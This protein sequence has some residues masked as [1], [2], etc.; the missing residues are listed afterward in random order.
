MSETTIALLG[1][2]LMGSG[3]AGRL[4]DAGYPL[5]VYNRNATK[6][7]PLVA[8]GATLTRSPREAAAGASVVISMLSDVPVARDLWL[9]RGEALVDIA[10]GTILVESSTVTVDW[11]LELNRAATEHGCVLVDAPVTGSRAQ[12]AAGQLLF[13]AGGPTDTLGK[14]DPVLRAMGRDVVHVGPVG[15]GAR[16]KLINNFLSGVQTAALAEALSMIERS[17]LDTQ[18]SLNVLTEGAPGSPIVKLLSGRMEPSGSMSPSSCSSSWPKI[19]ATPLARQT[20]MRSI[21]IWVELHYAFLSTPSPQA[22]VT[23]TCPPWWSSS[24]NT[25]RAKDECGPAVKKRLGR[26]YGNWMYRWET[27]LTTRDTNRIVRPVEWGFDWLQDF[28]S[29]YG[30]PLSAPA[31]EDYV[32]SERTM[33]ALNDFI[34]RHRADFFAYDTPQILCSKS[35]ILSSFR[36]MSAPRPCSG[37][38]FCA[39]RQS[40]ASSP[41]RSSCGLLRRCARL[42]RKTTA[43]TPVGSLRPSTR[44]QVNQSRP[45]SSCRSGTPT[46]FSHNALCSIFNRFGVSALRLSK[47]YHDIR[48]PAELERADYA[49]SANVGRTFASCRQA[50]I[51][52][53][54][55]Y[56]LAAAAGATSNSAFWAPAWAPAMRFSPARWMNGSA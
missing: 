44:W 24:V 43:S 6:A 29:A 33:L 41:W 40:R 35:V 49:V 3:M 17:G 22:R 9:G 50:V 28:T 27:A 21:W 18:K 19:F 56:R 10:P 42:I 16:L 30:F 12:A 34:L 39:K 38:P 20:R 1:L 23:T 26:L 11:I 5:R 15:S 37:T 47:P 46:R 7:E 45:S 13:L 54:L 53:R 52:I 8:R 14:I 25:R 51:D 55:L 31:A 36:R 48:R 2:G 32:A 4:L